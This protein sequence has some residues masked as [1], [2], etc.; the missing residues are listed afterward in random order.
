MGISDFPDS[1]KNYTEAAE[2]INDNNLTDRNLIHF[3]GSHIFNSKAEYG[4]IHWAG[5]TAQVDAKSSNIP[6]W[7]PSNNRM[8]ATG[9]THAGEELFLDPQQVAYLNGQGIVTGLNWIGGLVGWGNRTGAYPGITDVKDTFIPIRRMVHFVGNTLVTTAWQMTDRPLNRRLKG[10]V[11]DTFNIW[12]NGLARREFLLGG[13]VEF[14]SDDNPS[15][16]I[17]DGI[18]RFR[19]FIA[20]ASPARELEFIIEYDP[21]Y[22]VA[23]FGLQE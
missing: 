10:T 6:Y 13:R 5:V 14:L 2:Y 8:M 3:F 7:S 1:V 23:A 11:C 9:M 18:S 4:S 20:P 22:I 15:T 17:M 21:S 12:L 16:D 19:V